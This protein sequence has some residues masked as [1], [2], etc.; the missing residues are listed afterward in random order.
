MT[1]TRAKEAVE[2]AIVYLTGY[3]ASL[4]MKEQNEWESVQDAI[5]ILHIARM[6][7]E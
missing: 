7:L 5:L 4:P 6:S 2:N 3:R 1:E